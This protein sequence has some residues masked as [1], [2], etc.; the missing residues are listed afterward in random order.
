MKGLFFA[1]PIEYRVETPVDV[2]VQGDALQGTMIMANRGASREDGL[3]MVV[4]LAY[5]DFKKI[6]DGEPGGLELT[7]Q[8]EL[9]KGIALEPGAEHKAEWEFALA[10][11]CPITSKEGSLFL[12]YG[13]ELD[14]ETGRSKIDLQVRLSPVLE[15]LV[16]GI[17]NHFAFAAKSRTHAM[18]FT[19]VRFKPPASYPTLEEM[20][21]LMRL[22]EKEG[23]ELL[24][25]C[26]AKKFDRSAGKGVKI[27][28]IEIE[29]SYPREEYLIHNSQPNRPLFKTIVESV[30][31]EATPGK[32]EKK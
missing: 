20:A 11:D 26:R 25:R 3:R 18:G 27:H 6:K 19:E 29:R 31:A 22:R 12:L 24:F 21:V 14:K 7:E 30:L 32:V 9:G 8:A 1:R 2:L 16:S 13:G 28:T 15:S 4:G 10:S 17:E 5:G 23:M